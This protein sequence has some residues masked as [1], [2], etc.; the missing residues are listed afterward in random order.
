MTDHIALHSG[1]IVRLNQAP[2]HQSPGY[3]RKA[4]GTRVTAHQY[5]LSRD[6]LTVERLIYEMFEIIAS[7]DPCI[8]RGRYQGR[9]FVYRYFTPPDGTDHPWTYWRMRQGDLIN[10]DHIDRA[11]REVIPRRRRKSPPADQLL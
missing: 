2:W 6:G 5:I 8:W 10:R 9:S 3:N 4:D 11:E 1:L 7:D